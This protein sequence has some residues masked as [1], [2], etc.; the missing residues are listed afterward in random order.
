MNNITSF[1]K[2]KNTKTDKLEDSAMYESAQ[3]YDSVWKVRTRMEIP[4]SLINAYVKKVQSEVGE[5]P[6]KRYSE[7]E[8]AEEIANYVSSSFLS[9]EN[10]PTSIIS[11]VQAQPQVQTSQDMPDD[12]QIQDE[13]EIQSQIQEPGQSQ[14]QE[15]TQGQGQI[16]GQGQGQG[17]GQTQAQEIA[18]EI[19]QPQTQQSQ[20][21][22]GQI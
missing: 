12:A 17:Q 6:K 7:Q 14:I 8:I 18:Q 4:V 3:L 13:E 20:I 15:P 10:L 19:P 16:Q 22:G 2:F 5:D 21:Q 1:N 9:V 11:N